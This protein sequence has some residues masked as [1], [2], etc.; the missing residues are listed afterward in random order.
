MTNLERRSGEALK[1]PCPCPLY[2]SKLGC[3]WS[4]EFRSQCGEILT[5]VPFSGHFSLRSAGLD[6]GYIEND[7]RNKIVFDNSQFIGL[8]I[9]IARAPGV[10]VGSHWSL[11]LLSS[12]P[13]LTRANIDSCPR[14]V[15]HLNNGIIM[16]IYK[17]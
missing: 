17:L 11:A 15:S 14:D 6:W 9:S 13:C 7:A 5:V 10:S 1:K 16:S 3:L 2:Q 8:S 12:I 4:K